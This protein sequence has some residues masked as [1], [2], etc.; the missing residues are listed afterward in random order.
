MTKVKNLMI[1]SC[2]IGVFYSKLLVFYVIFS[3]LQV[4]PCVSCIFTLIDNDRKL[5]RNEDNAF[6]CKVRNYKE[7]K[8][9]PQ[10]HAH[11]GNCFWFRII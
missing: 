1:K 10:C 8:V 6:F 11:F 7:L 2:N 3:V 9:N 5:I 4:V